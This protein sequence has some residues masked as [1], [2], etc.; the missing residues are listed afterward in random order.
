[1][2]VKVKLHE[3][4]IT[5]SVDGKSVALMTIRSLDEIANYIRESEK[6]EIIDKLEQEVSDA[7]NK[8]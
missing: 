7:I 4:K 6:D 8:V 5:D 1:M 3:I 2:E